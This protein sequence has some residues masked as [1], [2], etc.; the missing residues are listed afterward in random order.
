MRD[1]GISEILLVGFSFGM[2]WDFVTTFLGVVSIV[3]GPNFS[4]SLNNI[5]SNTFG[6]YGIAFVGTVIVFCFNLLTISVWKEAREGQWTLV[7]PW[8]LCVVFDF[9]TSLA[10]NYRFILP[11]RQNQ[12]AVIGVVWFTTLLTTISPMTVRYLIM[13]YEDKNR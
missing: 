5:D 10:G 2:L 1:K 9:F 6:V 13:D 7:A 4:I 8:F 12:I 11:G 3:A